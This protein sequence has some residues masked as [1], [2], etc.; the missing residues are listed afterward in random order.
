MLTL[1]L[2]LSATECKTTLLKQNDPAPCAGYLISPEAAA[3]SFDIIENLYPKLQE[4]ANL[5][6]SKVSLLGEQLKIDKDII[7]GLKEQIVIY[8]KD[9]KEL[10]EFS[11]KS[12]LENDKQLKLQTIIVVVSVGVTI[13]LMTGAILAVGYLAQSFTPR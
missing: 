2:L 3:K 1:L 11:Q 6:E 13:V 10:L 7:D 5:L 4:K 9:V 8:K 12:L